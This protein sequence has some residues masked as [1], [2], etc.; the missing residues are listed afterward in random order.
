MVLEATQK[1]EK[2]YRVGCY[3]KLAKLW[4]KRKDTAIEYH[5]DY[6]ATKFENIGN[7][8]IVDV[9]IDITGKKSIAKRPEMIRLIKACMQGEV[10]C[11]VTQTK[12]Y[13]AANMQEFCYLLKLLFEFNSRIDIVTEDELLNIDTITN[14]DSQ[15]AALYAMAN[16]YIAIKPDDYQKWVNNI[17]LEVSNTKG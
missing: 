12:A 17:F 5:K 11:I 10:N 8:K 13:L 14:A 1:L 2:E 16:D 15:R 9:Y 3:V 7:Y 6:Y 4:E